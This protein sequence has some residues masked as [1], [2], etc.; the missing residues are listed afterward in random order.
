MEAPPPSVAPDPVAWRPRRKNEVL[1]DL[2]SPMGGVLEGAK[3][4]LAIGLQLG[5]CKS[6]RWSVTGS[7]Y[8]YYHAKV[9]AGMSTP[10]GKIYPVW[11]LHPKGYVL[12]ENPTEA[13]EKSYGS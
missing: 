7:N 5:D 2:P 11:P 1:P 4:C 9:E 10:T 13:K 6:Q 12:L 8:C 3:R